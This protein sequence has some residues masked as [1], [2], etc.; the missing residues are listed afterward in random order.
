MPDDI[1]NPAIDPDVDFVPLA[2]ISEASLLPQLHELLDDAGIAYVVTN[3]GVQN[4]VGLGAAVFGWNPATGAP[5]LSV[6]PARLEEAR[7]LLEPL[8][9]PPEPNPAP[10]IVPSECPVC[11]QRLESEPGDAPIANCYHCGASLTEP[12]QN[13]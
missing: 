9:A 10:A 4:L 1:K 6:E 7:A 12:P 8:F 3:E 13:E 5:V 11:H 2:A